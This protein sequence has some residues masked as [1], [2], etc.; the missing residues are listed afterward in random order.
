MAP[1]RT[2]IDSAQIG[3]IEAVGLATVAFPF[4]CVLVFLYVGLR[5]LGGS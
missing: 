2:Q 5:G 3:D 1:S 4:A